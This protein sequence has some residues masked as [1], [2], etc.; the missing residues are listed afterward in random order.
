[1]LTILA[2]KYTLSALFFAQEAISEAEK[3]VRFNA[4]FPQCIELCIANIQ[5]KNK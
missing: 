4:V 3:Q 2:E 1:V 5:A